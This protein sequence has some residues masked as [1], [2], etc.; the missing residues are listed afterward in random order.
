MSIH[1][2]PLKIPNCQEA[3]ERLL[4]YLDAAIESPG[5]V[6]EGD[7]MRFQ[8]IAM[9]LELFG[10]APVPAKLLWLYQE[11]MGVEPHDNPDPD[12]EREAV[13][14]DELLITMIRPSPRD[15]WKGPT[16]PILARHREAKAKHFESLAKR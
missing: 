8:S 9:V 3:A 16:E 5:G 1:H 7:C 4:N 12:P 14:P 6:C 2:L 10:D 11:A 15:D 13:I